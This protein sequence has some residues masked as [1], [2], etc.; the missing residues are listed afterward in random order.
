MAGRLGVI[1]D[2]VAMPE[3]EA[4]AFWERFS[5]H[6][7]EHKGDLAGFAH[8]EGFA[9]VHPEMRSGA[10]VLIV[11]RTAPQRAYAN[12]PQRG[13]GSGSGSPPPHPKHPHHHRKQGKNKPRPS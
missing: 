8:A 13:G 5:A 4:R 3:E 10:P 9:S 6:M 2:G 12:A 7:D 1:V 11:S